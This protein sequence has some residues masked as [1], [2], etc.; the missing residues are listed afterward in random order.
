M[1]RRDPNVTGTV[2]ETDRGNG[3][4]G[5]RWRTI[6]RRDVRVEM[7]ERRAGRG[8]HRPTD[9]GQGASIVVRTMFFGAG[10][11]TENRAIR[12]SITDSEKMLTHGVD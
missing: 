10:R 9:S 4:L 5:G 11:D 2:R 1:R 6:D 3:G 12:E 7:A 8:R